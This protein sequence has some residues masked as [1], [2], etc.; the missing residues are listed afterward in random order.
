M[1]LGGELGYGPARGGWK[2][3]AD[4]PFWP[5]F[6]RAVNTWPRR[7]C[8]GK[9]SQSLSASLLPQF[10]LAA[11]VI[12]M[13]I[14]AA[15]TPAPRSDVLASSP[16]GTPAAMTPAQACSWS[17][18]QHIKPGRGQDQ[19]LHQGRFVSPPLARSHVSQLASGIPSDP[20]LSTADARRSQHARGG[21]G[22]RKARFTV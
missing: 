22:E 14:T 19:A 13:V 11:A 16:A 3:K 7:L 20:V 8:G 17:Y 10:I 18:Q 2:P 15:Q 4:L 21:L 12:V 5:Q 9:A 6:W 1:K